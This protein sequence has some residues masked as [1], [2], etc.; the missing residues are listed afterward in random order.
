MSRLMNDGG[1]A[2][3]SIYRG[4]YLGL[5]NWPV[6]KYCTFARHL[7]VMEGSASL[8]LGLRCP[9]SSIQGGGFRDSVPSFLGRS[10][11]EAPEQRQPAAGAVSLIEHFL[12]S[13]CIQLLSLQPLPL[14]NLLLAM[15]IRAETRETVRDWDSAY[16]IGKQIFK[17][18]DCHNYELVRVV[19]IKIQAIEVMT[20]RITSTVMNNV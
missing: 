4:E 9:V 12:S 19:V 2:A 10:E 5:Y 8:I 1:T 11:G 15:T 16:A 13:R 18:Y 7:L 3:G 17:R 14:A 20:T 6:M